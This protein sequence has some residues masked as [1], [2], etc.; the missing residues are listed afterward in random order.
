M[1]HIHR[2]VTRNFMGH[3]ELDLTLPDQGVVVITGDNGSGKSSL[4][5][6]VSVG[7]WGKTI[8]GTPWWRNGIVGQVRIETDRYVITRERDGKKVN[9]TKWGTS[10]GSLKEFETPTRSQSELTAV[11]G[12][13]DAW[14]RASV[15][16]STD[17]LGFST[18]TDGERKR[19]LEQM[20]GLDVFDTGLTACRAE[21]SAVRARM[22]ELEG[23]QQRFQARLHVQK[24]RLDDA[25][26]ALGEA[27]PPV[28]TAK[29]QSTLKSYRAAETD[30]KN[31]NLYVGGLQ[32]RYRNARAKV[33]SARQQLE[34]LKGTERCWTCGQVL[35]TSARNRLGQ[36]ARE[37][38]A[39]AERDMPVAAVELDRVRP[40]LEELDEEVEVLRDRV[41]TMRKNLAL[42][43]EWEKRAA[44][45]DVKVD[46]IEQAIK[47]LQAGINTLNENM[48][49]AQK[50]MLELE[51]VEQIL[52]LK[53]ARVHVVFRAAKAIEV[54]A[55]AWLDRMLP[56][57]KVRT[58]AGREGRGNNLGGLGTT[59]KQGRKPKI[60]TLQLA[61]S[62]LADC[63]DYRACSGGERRRIDVALL[64]ALAEV[65]AASVGAMPGTLFVDEVFDSLDRDGFSAV[66]EAL[67][68]VATSR[69]VVVVTHSDELIHALD[70]HRH[71]H[72]EKGQ[73]EG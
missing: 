7:L 10:E 60:D 42:R 37:E 52:G 45:K 29:L 44:Q 40:Q 23:K 33:S 50:E 9:I 63:A 53:G 26:E 66:G 59:F 8:R 47:N 1:H 4:I 62:G 22:A 18:S 41:Q 25:A 64:L 54:V 3:R 2:I 72:F 69:C 57:V 17:L 15:F 27:P 13:L 34:D 51:T 16:S 24:S 68:E 70:H 58:S 12:Q 46:E 38:L 48:R 73:A 61:I 39:T 28:D 19:F 21:M 5:E 14:R 67:R 6:A 36:S 32:G 65:R 30:R 43:E 56:G 31:A 49:F 20:L 11:V 71:I 55:N 35:D